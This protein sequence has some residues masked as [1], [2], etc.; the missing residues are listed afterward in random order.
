MFTN[1]SGRTVAVMLLILGGLILLVWWVMKDP[2]AEFT[3]NLPG[4]DNRVSQTDASTE[5]VNIGE[6]FQVFEEATSS[7]TESW[8]RF[9][10]QARRCI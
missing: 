9:A 8:P 6:N 1:N 5:E 10:R 2:A 4:T 7:L 3:E